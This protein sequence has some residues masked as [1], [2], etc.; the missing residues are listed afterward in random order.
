MVG[1]VVGG[2]EGEWWEDT[3]SLA[4]PISL[5]SL[6]FPISSAFPLLSRVHR[7]KHVTCDI[8]GL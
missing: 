4:F 6:A 1:G 5:I 2:V 7:S 3:I 8:H